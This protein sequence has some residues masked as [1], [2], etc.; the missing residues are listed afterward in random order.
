ME[1]SGKEQAA[2]Q[3]IR[4]LKEKLARC[5][6]IESACSVAETGL[7]ATYD[8]LKTIY[9][10]MVDGIL[11]ADIETKR[12]LFSN[13]S[14]ENNLGYSSEEL[15]SMNVLQIHPPDVRDRLADSFTAAANG[16][17]EAEPEV[18]CLR[19]DG[20][21]FFADLIIRHLNF[22]GR[23][24]LIGFFRDITDRLAAENEQKLAAKV[25]E[26]AN[27]G[28][29]ITDRL[30]NV[31]DANNSF[32]EMTGYSREEIIG[33]NPRLMKSGRHSAEFF[34]EMWDAIINQGYWRGEIWDRRK[35]GE[36]Y[37]K[38]LSISSI[39]NEQ[40]EITHFIGISSDITTV[41]QSEANLY[42]LAY[43]DALT[44][45]PNR[46]HYY[47]RIQQAIQNAV[48]QKTKLAVMFIDLD[49]FK[50]VNDDY[51]HL[52]GDRLLVYVGERLEESVRDS[53]TVSRYGGDE[54]AVLLPDI[55]N[56]SKAAAIAQRIVE[57]LS[58]PFILD[59]REVT[60]GGSV[61]IAIYPMDGEDSDT[62]M[63]NADTAMYHAKQSDSRQYLFFSNEM[64]LQMSQ[65]LQ[66]EERLR[67]ALDQDH[68]KVYYQPKIDIVSG[69]MI[70]CE[71]LLR[72]EDPERGMIM[73]LE[74]IL[75]AEE[76]NIIHDIGRMVLADACRKVKHWNRLVSRPIKV[77]VNMTAREL[78]MQ[79]PA[80]LLDRMI[81]ESGIDPTTLEIEITERVMMDHATE[82]KSKLEEV[83]ALGVKISIDD[84][85]TGYTSINYLR[86][87]P[88]D[89][90]KI[91]ISYVRNL[92]HDNDSAAIVRAI[93]S[94][95]KAL[96]LEVTAEGVEQ[97]QQ[98]IFLK[99]N[100]CQ[101]VQGFYYSKA[102][103]ADEIEVILKENRRLGPAL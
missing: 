29:I 2:E 69:E 7:R 81:A 42:R 25:Y 66:L 22:R 17:I 15:A 65:R 46:L 78:M 67:Y 94:L 47:E 68:L 77:A 57:S 39:R 54:Y 102:V 59:S 52:V 70:G 101:L 4:E 13:P 37:P 23:S 51:G 60:I 80:N 88:L 10:A 35:N 100:G 91:D 36:V 99:E 85:G 11:I 1:N 28:I 62:L 24:C 6:D 53:D 95:A 27:D 16:E 44:G 5:Q 82:L 41:K 45:L 97:A 26:T 96:K 89:G 31:V 32:C 83:K 8:Q 84:F 55:A 61:G 76:S 30:G 38:W 75:T 34:T 98:L 56:P 74:F 90:L 18:P 93:I 20:S 63:K 43:Y 79:N 71:A 72:W 73:P 64:N 50:R 14:I 12:F 19:K 58:R 92:P 33:Q 49:K 48:R 87:Y 3:E 40:N 86:R 103:T 9:D 21:T